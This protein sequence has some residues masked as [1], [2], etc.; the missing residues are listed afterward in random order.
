MLYNFESWSSRLAVEESFT[1]DVLL[2]D[3]RQLYF[4]L[5]FASM[6]WKVGKW[7]WT[8]EQSY[9]TWW[10]LQ[11]YGES[12]V[13][14]A[15][16]GKLWWEKIPWLLRSTGKSIQACHI[17][18]HGCELLS[19][20]SRK[21]QLHCDYS[22][23]QFFFQLNVGHASTFMDFILI[24]GHACKVDSLIQ[25]HTCKVPPGRSFFIRPLFVASLFLLPDAFPFH[26]GGQYQIVISHL[27]NIDSNSPSAT[28]QSG[29]WLTGKVRDH[30]NRVNWVYIFLRVT[31]DYFWDVGYLI[32]SG[33]VTP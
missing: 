30:K 19:Q 32:A 11:L 28:V 23:F 27:I 2:T 22:G 5:A 3:D 24:Q 9:C 21:R 17:K 20:E 16:P 12:L 33:L 15:E 25:G 7:L 14:V 26:A 10:E 4:V 18:C 31:H 8:I 1:D 13:C 29:W 6:L